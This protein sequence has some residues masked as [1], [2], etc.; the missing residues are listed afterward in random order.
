MQG[1]SISEKG[2]VPRQVQRLKEEQNITPTYEEN[3]VVVFPR[4]NG[5]ITYLGT[6]LVSPAFGV[7]TRE[8]SIP[9]L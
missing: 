5:V 2:W 3:T 9:A 1:D 7:T 4:F 8:S 6:Y